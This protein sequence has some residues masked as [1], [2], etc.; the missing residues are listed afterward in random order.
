MHFFKK[1]S[2]ANFCVENFSHFSLSFHLSLHFIHIPFTKKVLCLSLIY[3]KILWYLNVNRVQSS[4]SLRKKTQRNCLDYV[5]A[6]GICSAAAI[7]FKQIR[8]EKLPWL[9]VIIGCVVGGLGK[10][11][12]HTISGCLY[13]DSPFWASL[14]YNGAYIIPSIVLCAIVMYV[15]FL[16]NPMLLTIE[17][18]K[19]SKVSE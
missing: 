5:F 6:Y 17:D 3:D 13:F 16:K 19:D 4:V 14:T 12:C 18:L 15:V 10:L 1:L 9:Y 8:G 7:F 11:L 2:T